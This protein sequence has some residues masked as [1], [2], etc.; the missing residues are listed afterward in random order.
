M[1]ERL[2]VDRF[3]GLGFLIS[4]RSELVLT[5]TVRQPSGILAEEAADPAAL[6]IYGSITIAAILCIAAPFADDDTIL[7]LWLAGGFWERAFALFLIFYGGQSCRSAKIS[8]ARKTRLLRRI[9]P[10]TQRRSF[11][12][13]I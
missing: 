9:A 4:Q 3:D 11:E 5:S 2:A 13:L 7:L 1:P 10:G 12:F 6:A 8:Y